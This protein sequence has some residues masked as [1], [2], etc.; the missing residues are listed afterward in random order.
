MD[1]V[2]AHHAFED[3]HILGVADLHE[4]VAASRLDVSLSWQ[5]IRAGSF[6]AV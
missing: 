6:T 4:Q 2:F 1:M 5:A 3:A